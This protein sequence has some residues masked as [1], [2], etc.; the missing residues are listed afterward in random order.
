MADNS[1]KKTRFSFVAVDKNKRPPSPIRSPSPSKSPKKAEEP[2][3][4]VELP[5]SAKVAFQMSTESNGGEVVEKESQPEKGKKE[6]KV[7][8][9]GE[10]EPVV[11][12]PTGSVVSGGEGE[13]EGD[14]SA[15]SVGKISVK[16]EKI[17]GVV[18]GVGDVASY[19]GTIEL[20]EKGELEFQ[21][22]H[23]TYQYVSPYNMAHVGS[24]ALNRTLGPQQNAEHSEDQNHEVPSEKEREKEEEDSGEFSPKSKK[25]WAKN[26]KVRTYENPFQGGGTSTPNQL[27]AAS[28]E[29]HKT[30]EPPK[31]RSGSAKRLRRFRS[32]NRM[33]NSNVNAFSDPSVQGL[34]IDEKKGMKFSFK[35]L[36][37]RKE[38]NEEEEFSKEVKRRHRCQTKREKVM[39]GMS[40]SCESTFSDRFQTVSQESAQKKTY[41]FFAEKISDLPPDLLASLERMRIARKDFEENFEVLLNILSFA[42][43]H[44]PRRRFVTHRQLEVVRQYRSICATNLTERVLLTP[45]EAYERQTFSEAKSNYKWDVYLGHGGFGQ[46]VQAK[47]RDKQDSLF[48]ERVALKFQS[49]VDPRGKRMN[50]EE[51]SLLKRCNHP[52]IVRLHRA[53]EVRSEVWMVMELLEGGNL[54]KVSSCKAYP[55]AERE[56]AYVSRETLQ[57]LQYLHINQ[58]AHRDLK[59]LNLMI[60]INGDVKLIDFGLAIDLSAGPRVQMVGSPLWMSPEMIRGK[61]HSY[62]VDVWSF[63]L[64]M[65]ELAN[66][67]PR[68]SGNLKRAMFITATIG[69]REAFLQPE[70]WSE[71]FKTFIE[72]AANPNQFER[73]SASELLTHRFISTACSKKTLREKLEKIYNQP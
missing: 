28:L 18:G 5:K 30:E 19:S 67:K 40:I 68:E 11:A 64:C 42:D 72:H 21:E 43:K 9:D 66:Q 47:C 44:V 69:I 41:S 38:R 4:N 23:Q 53:L 16:A 73:P 65:L 36:P 22:N 63:V 35:N 29:K 32:S 13:G 60:S 14:L 33:A 54:R 49:N 70:R 8:S 17:L 45:E 59:D 55:L 12:S 50:L 51:V 56:I 39:R 71:T 46:V 62:G 37:F 61:P 52:N 34:S 31:P 57:A 7:S 15:R 1:K 20:N 26:T 25:P 6:M 27:T 58:I 10:N 3:G 2:V 48:G 24:L